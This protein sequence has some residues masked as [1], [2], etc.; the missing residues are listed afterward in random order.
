M[1]EQN[2][3]TIIFGLFLILTCRDIFSSHKGGQADVAQPDLA[4]HHHHHHHHHHDSING[5]LLKSPDSLDADMIGIPTIKI[6]FCHSCGYRQ[7]FEDIAKMLRTAFPNMKVDG[8]YHHPAWF[9]TQ[10][11]NVLFL[12]KVAVIAMLFWNINP[13]TYLQMETPRIWT[14]ITQSKLS[15]SILIWM[16]IGSI[17]SSMMS[18]GAFEIFFNDYPIWSKIQ[19][20]RIPSAPE[21][22]QIVK[23]QLELSDSLK[24]SAFKTNI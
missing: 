3:F 11:V 24:S 8:E 1:I 23:S 6:Q 20:G 22:I 14:H 15:S 10:L 7:A 13:F 19:T 9:K 18:T 2:T 5:D 4:D 21:L 17:E 16:V 12:T